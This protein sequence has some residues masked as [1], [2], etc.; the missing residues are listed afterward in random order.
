MRRLLENFAGNVTG[1]SDGI[2]VGAEAE[3]VIVRPCAGIDALQIFYAESPFNEKRNSLAAL[4][5]KNL[6][7]W[8]KEKEGRFMKNGRRN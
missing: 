4:V 2:R 8:I 1:I 3:C 7:A 6:T 5:T